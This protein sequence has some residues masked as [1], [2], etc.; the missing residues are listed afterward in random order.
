VIP[1]QLHPLVESGSSGHKKR[2]QQIAAVQA[3]GHLLIAA[4]ET[5]H[6]RF[7]VTFQSRTVDPDF[8]GTATYNDVLAEVA[9]Q[10]SRWPD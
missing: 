5:H 1:F 10:E 8:L 2:R 9:T 4:L 7:G 3:E 6:E